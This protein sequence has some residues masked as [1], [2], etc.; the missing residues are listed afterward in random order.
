M[1]NFYD[2]DRI[3]IKFLKIKNVNKFFIHNSRSSFKCKYKDNGRP[4]K[5]NLNF[6]GIYFVSGYSRRNAEIFSPLG[7]PEITIR[8]SIL[9]R[10]Q[11]GSR[12]AWNTRERWGEGW[13][14]YRRPHLASEQCRQWRQWRMWCVACCCSLSRLPRWMTGAVGRH[15]AADRITTSGN[16]K[17][18]GRFRACY[19]LY[20]HRVKW[21]M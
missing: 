21:K 6:I 5:C 4:V 1:S 11:R 9:Y 18:D 19:I 8:H 10:E 3:V 2:I 12:S 13:E 14:F 17:D 7:L 16:T 15:R 20:S